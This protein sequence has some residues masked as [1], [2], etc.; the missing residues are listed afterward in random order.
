MQ[1]KV[2]IQALTSGPTQK[3]IFDLVGPQ[4]L[5]HIENHRAL[6]FQRRRRRNLYGLG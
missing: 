6:L 1:G 3:V 2:K 4:S 5:S